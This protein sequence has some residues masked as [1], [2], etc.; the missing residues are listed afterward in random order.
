MFGSAS[1]K[2]QFI[3]TV[4]AK[5]AVK[6]FEQVGKAADKDLKKAE[7]RL[8]RIGSNMTKVGAG[9]M[10]FAGVVGTAL[11]GAAKAYENQVRA[12]L[13]LQNTIQNMPKLAGESAEQFYELARAIQA[14]T[15]AGD[16]EV[17]SAMAMLGTFQLTAAEIK[18]ITPLVVDYARKFDVDLVSAATQ[19]GKALDGQMGAL[20]RNGVSIDEALFKTDRYAAV[21]QALSN[22]VGGFA[23]EEAKTFT[24]QIQQMKNQLGDIVE[25]IGSGVVPAF[26]TM[27]GWVGKG[28]DAFGKLDPSVRAGVG[29]F[30]AWGTA[31]LGAAGALSFIGGQVIKHRARFQEMFTTVG[32]DGVRSFNTWGKVATGALAAVSA[33]LVV[34]ALHQ[35]R[36][37]KHE[38]DRV[39]NQQNLTRLSLDQAD[40]VARLIEAELALGRSAESLVEGN[41]E[42]ALSMQ[43]FAN[44]SETVRAALDKAGVSSERLQEIIDEEVAAQ[45]RRNQVTADATSLIEDNAD[46]TED[47]TEK[48]GW[49]ADAAKR[50]TDGLKAQKDAQD[51]AN[52]ATKDAIDVQRAAQDSTYAVERAVWA[53][54]DALTEYAATAVDGAATER[55]KTTAL[56]EAERAFIEQAVTVAQAAS[57]VKE[58]QDGVALSAG[59][60]GAIQVRELQKVASSLAPGDPLR[61]NLEAYIARLLAVPAV[62]DTNLSLNTAPAWQAL[63]DLQRRMS[64]GFVTN[65]HVVGTGGVPIRRHSGGDVPGPRGADVPAILQAGEHVISAD[66]VDA[67]KRGQ[68]TRGKGGLSST[69]GAGSVTNNY[70]IHLASLD[71]RQ[72]GDILIDAIREYER[73]NGSQWRAA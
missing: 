3:L 44:E 69:V 8:D 10:A 11:F 57:D 40:A 22:Q 62:V 15:V 71:P 54:E 67:I 38:A 60:M 52:R 31:I 4:D 66:V 29:T 68:P 58:A 41:L 6:A 26:G 28:V 55:D 14:K 21:Q 53:A 27:L 47:A 56:R 19:V 45:Q 25:E 16:E 46:A 64:Q 32:A 43:R 5:G 70:T 30:A 72:A 36:A 48:V 13:L 39:Q 61:A 73:R 63:N 1:Q 2:L 35:Q 7:D 65:M 42:A 17:I 37:A 33:A 12:E 23:E 51:K 59:E 50:V 24:G 34:Y 20:K 18:N 9:A 49:Y